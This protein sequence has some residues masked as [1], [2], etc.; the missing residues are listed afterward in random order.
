[1]NN[2]PLTASEPIISM[3][4]VEAVG[5][6]VYR[7]SRRKRLEILLIK[8]QGGFWTLPKGHVEPG[9][10]HNEAAIREIREE[11]GVTC[12]VGPYITEVSY[13]VLKRGTPRTKT[14]SY[15]LMHA[16]RG[17]L[18][19]SKKERISRVKWFSF[20]EAQRRIK[21]GRVRAI[22]QQASQLLSQAG[23]G[24]ARGESKSIKA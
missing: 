20:E 16:T 17:R 23:I 22:V 18:R 2:G 4:P 21:R 10:S 13:I 6:V 9:E 12:T 3:P 8:K 19:P 11:T 14:V 5:G 1:M 24:P 7:V 15:Y